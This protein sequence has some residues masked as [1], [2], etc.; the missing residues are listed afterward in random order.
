MA[1]RLELETVRAHRVASLPPLPSLRLDLSAVG[2][3]ANVGAFHETGSRGR[4]LVQPPP[5]PPTL[6]ARD[7]HPVARDNRAI[8]Q[9]L[10]DTG[11]LGS[12]LIVKD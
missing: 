8:I 2:E 5:S 12:L 4:P 3:T 7:V 6:S 11:T 10:H 9:E 1:D